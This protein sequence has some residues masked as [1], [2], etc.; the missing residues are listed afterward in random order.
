[1]KTF[2]HSGDMGDLIYS[3]PIIKHMGGASCLFLNPGGLP[4]R[5]YDGSRSGLDPTL[6]KFIQPL[7]E[8][9]SYIE[10]VKTWQRETVDVN[11]DEFRKKNIRYH[12]VNLCEEILKVFGVPFEITKKSWIEIEPTK[13]GNEVFSRSSRY[14][15]K[16]ANL[17]G[18]LL[19]STKPVF[20]GLFDEWYNFGKKVGPIR[21]HKVKDALEMAS[22]IAGADLFIGNQSFGMAL[23]IAL[24]QNYVQ[25]VYTRC[26]NCIFE[27]E[28][29][30]YL[31]DDKP[32]VPSPLRK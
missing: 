32:P 6:I 5:K 9:Q 30:T 17:R 10:K 24:G 12:R 28:N 29:A 8:N 31:V 21:F 27:R 4:G 19:Q 13:I 18:Y 26:K 2:K 25:E 11:I 16:T 20:V 23:A 22:I 14:Q 1:M 7:L 3:L 15:N